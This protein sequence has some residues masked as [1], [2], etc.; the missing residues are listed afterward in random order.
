METV[1]CLHGFSQRGESWRELS[2]LVAG[3]L[4]WLTPDVASTSPDAALA[5]ILGLWHRERVPRSHLVGYSAGGRLAL[6]LALGHPER[7]LT[8]TVI[9][10][11][12]GF[13]GAVRLARL[14]DDEELARR[15][16]REGIDWFADHW[17]SLPMFAGLARRRP[18]L[19]PSLDA[20]R[21]SQDPR[22]LAAA[23]RGM[24]G[25]TGEPL[26]DRLSSIELV[27]LVIVGAD[28]L[29]YLE[30]ARRLADLIPSC[31]VEAVPD[32]GHAAHLEN[33]RAV[34]ALLAS[35]LSRR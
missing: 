30:H 16:E 1:T 5:E 4:R 35:H 15:I 34:A 19:L 32:A 23:L 27:T 33:P 9:G 20:A 2:S 25:A 13:E 22:R 7:L 29:P 24:G 14:Q 3:D 21:R 26:W 31:R 11:H 18:D 28:D 10:T 6:L 12:A 8:L 17:A